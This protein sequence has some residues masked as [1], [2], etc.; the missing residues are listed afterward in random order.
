MNGLIPGASFIDID[1]LQ[2]L[3]L[4]TTA[5]L[6]LNWRGDVVFANQSAEQL[7]E[8][9]RKN[10]VGQSAQRLFAS[11]SAITQLMADAQANALGQRRQLLELK[12]PLRDPLPVQATASA[13]YSHET[14]LVIELVEV[15]QQ[16]KVSREER[17][18]DLTELTGNCC[19]TWR[20]RSRTRW[21]ESAAP[22]S[23]SRA[24]SER[25]TSAS[26]RA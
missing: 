6:V 20:T 8:T 1:R 26:T 23:C 19:A 22:H 5:V 18:L 17:Q 15:E 21:A 24:S 3:D 12:R 4:L 25:L 9:S 14:P 10:L 2:G 16:M 13:L 7:F 11:D